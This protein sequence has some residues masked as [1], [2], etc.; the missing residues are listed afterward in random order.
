MARRLSL[1]ARRA[2]LAGSTEEVEVFLVVIE[3]PD[4]GEP[5]LLSTDNGVT[6][7][8]DPL[9]YGTRSTWAFGGVEGIRRDFPMVLMSAFAPDDQEDTPQAAQIVVDLV[10]RD[11]VALVRATTERADVHMAMVLAS[12]PDLV[13]VEWLGLKLIAADPDAGQ[14]I[15]SMS[16]EPIT[17]EPA[18]AVRMSRDVTPCL[19]Q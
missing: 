3:H 9:V 2:H 11:I 17:A 4:I 12:T 14:V 5:M 18:T 15:L 13:E 7:S 1:N 8:T 10:D 19:H 6:L 16:R